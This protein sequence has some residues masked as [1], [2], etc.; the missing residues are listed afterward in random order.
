MAAR[1]FGPLKNQKFVHQAAGGAFFPSGSSRQRGVWGSAP[2][3]SKSAHSPPDLR[4]F[5]SP[6][7]RVGQRPPHCPHPEPVRHCQAQWTRSCTLAG[8][9]PRKTPH[10]PQQQ[11]RLTATVRKLYT[12]LSAMEDG[13]ACCWRHGLTLALEIIEY[14]VAGLYADELLPLW[15]RQKSGWQVRENCSHNW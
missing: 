6:L 5:A 2:G 10:Q 9:H 1:A 7:T 14:T 13:A 11:D 3:A 4:A 15:I 12:G 8:R